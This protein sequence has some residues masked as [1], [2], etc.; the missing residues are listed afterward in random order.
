MTGTVSEPVRA[1]LGAPR[2]RL[3]GRTGGQRA[4]DPV[5]PEGTTFNAY[6]TGPR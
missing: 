3:I 5:Q 2:V 4:A 1:A 6:S